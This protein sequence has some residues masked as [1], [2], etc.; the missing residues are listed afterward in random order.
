[1]ATLN[2]RV[3]EVSMLTLPPTASSPEPF[4]ISRPVAAPPPPPTVLA[5]RPLDPV[6]IMKRSRAEG[7]RGITARQRKAIHM[8]VRGRTYKD[9]AKRLNMAESNISDWKKQPEFQDQLCRRRAEFNREIDQNMV[10]PITEARKRAGKY[11]P[12]AVDRLAEV[13]EGSDHKIVVQA[14]KVLLDNAGV[15]KQAPVQQPINIVAD[16]AQLVMGVIAKGKKT[17]GDAP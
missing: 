1:M 9:I 15:K 6:A 3:C 16:H 2:G 11:A 12:R 7:V 14:I 4:A 8:L 17:N 5:T 13:M 10:D